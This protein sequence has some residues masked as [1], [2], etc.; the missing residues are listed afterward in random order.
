MKRHH[1][2]KSL[3]IERYWDDSKGFL[4]DTI[5][6]DGTPKKDMTVNAVIPVFF[7]IVGCQDPC[8]ER[9]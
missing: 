4:Y 8:K 2:L 9:S 5:Q 3:I 6:P 7:D 1:E